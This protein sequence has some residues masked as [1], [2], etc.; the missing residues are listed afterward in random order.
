MVDFNNKLKSFVD[1]AK[2][3]ITEIQNDEKLRDT[4]SDVVKQ[5]Q[6]HVTDITND[7]KV[8]ELVQQGKKNL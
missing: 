6:D 5:I 8:Q 4:V 1:K 7:E 3:K 2:Q